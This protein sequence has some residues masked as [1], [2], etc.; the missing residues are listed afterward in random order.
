M[1]LTKLRTAT[2]YIF[3]DAARVAS[4]LMLE[5]DF[6]P[7]T[8][9][10]LALVSCL[11]S[12][13]TEVPKSTQ[14]E[15][16]ASA[17]SEE[18][19]EAVKE[20]VT[21][22]R[23]RYLRNPYHDLHFDLSDRNAI[24][25][26]TLYL[27]GK[28]ITDPQQKVLSNSAQLIGHAMFGRW[29]RVQNLLKENRDFAQ[30]AVQMVVKIINDTLKKVESSGNANLPPP[31]EL[32]YLPG[33]PSVTP[34]EAQAYWTNILKYPVFTKSYLENLASTLT[35][36]KSQEVS[37]ISA[38]EL[39]LSSAL[40][41]LED[42]EI[43]AQENIYQ[44]WEVLRTKE[45]D[46]QL[47]RF[48]TAEVLDNVQDTLKVLKEKEEVIFFFDKEEEWMM[49][50]PADEQ[51]GYKLS[52]TYRPTN[53]DKFVKVIPPKKTHAKKKKRT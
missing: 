17:T 46:K 16:S 42:K 47:K 41:E 31:H 9:T 25:G 5:E 32:P 35:T 15:A 1:N 12:V 44:S 50:L 7:P 37:L 8:T 22:V 40:S 34:Q 52:E 4:L 48:R 38:A 30:E 10:Y 21:K 24:V 19:K 45:L 23:V 36:V 11:K 13:I 26:K 43:N 49:R 20:D 18:T 14:E 33:S 53:W 2:I 6:G 29:D 28:Q 51:Q 27:L 39:L 3:S